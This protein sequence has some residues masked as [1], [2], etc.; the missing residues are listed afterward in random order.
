LCVARE[1]WVE[2]LGGLE[3]DMNKEG[4]F[5]VR[6]QILSHMGLISVR[7]VRNNQ[8]RM[9]RACEMREKGLLKAWESWSPECTTGAFLACDAKYR[10]PRARYWR[11]LWEMGSRQ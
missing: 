4:R 11:D 3:A 6:N 8:M 5:E 1:R 10:G 9:V 7:T 2:R